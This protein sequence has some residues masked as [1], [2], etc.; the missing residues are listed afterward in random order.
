MWKIHN[1]VHIS[2]LE[3]DTI[4]KGRVEIAIELDKGNKKEYEVEAICNSAVYVR[5]SEEHLLS[6]YYLVF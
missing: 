4:K 6:F 2:L 5:K 3:Q 1:I